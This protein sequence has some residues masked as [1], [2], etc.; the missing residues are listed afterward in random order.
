ME[1]V[2]NK[3]DV[4]KKKSDIISE[5]MEEIIAPDTK[6]DGKGTD[7]MTCMIV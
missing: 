1:Y 7:N 2:K 6:G 4:I 5:L 3:I